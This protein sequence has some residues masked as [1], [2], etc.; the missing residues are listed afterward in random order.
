MST[1]GLFMCAWRAS[2]ATGRRRSDGPRA[3]E[4]PRRGGSRNVR[5]ARPRRE[6]PRRTRSVTLLEEGRGV[7]SFSRF[8]PGS[9]SNFYTFTANFYTFTLPAKTRPGHP[10]VDPWPNCIYAHHAISRDHSTCARQIK[11]KLNSYTNCIM[12]TYYIMRSSTTFSARSQRD[13]SEITARS[14]RDRARLKRY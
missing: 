8:D 12:I 7:N 6:S 4:G 9:K 5:C 13:H 10:A 14:Q 3:A 11:S 1:V 2:A